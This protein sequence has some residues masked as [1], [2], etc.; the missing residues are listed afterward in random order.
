[1]SAADSSDK[2]G[3]GLGGGPLPSP[4]GRLLAIDGLS[5]T[6]RVADEASRT[7]G[8]PNWPPSGAH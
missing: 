4:D 7:F 8:V 6:G 1:M 5:W 3:A 2:E